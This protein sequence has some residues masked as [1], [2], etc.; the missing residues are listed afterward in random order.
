LAECSFPD[1]FTQEAL[2]AGVRSITVAV[3]SEAAVLSWLAPAASHIAGI[4]SAVQRGTGRGPV[5][6]R[7]CRTCCCDVQHYYL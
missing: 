1:E 3:L 7:F 6:A 4:E 5:R 2:K